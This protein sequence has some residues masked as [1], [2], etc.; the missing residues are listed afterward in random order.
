MMAFEKNQSRGPAIK[1][2]VSQVSELPVLPQVVYKIV[3]LTSSSRTTPADIE[4]IV[5]TDP[6]LVAKLLVLANSSHFG[7]DIPTN[8]IVEAA[9]RLGVN[10]IRQL[11]MT[12]TMFDMFVGKAD[13]SSRR[14]REWWRHSVDAAVCAQTL[15]EHLGTEPG[16]AYTCGLLHDMGKPLLERHGIGDYSEVEAKVASGDTLLKAEYEVYGCDHTEIGANVAELL[17]LP[18]AIVQAVRFHHDPPSE[19]GIPE[20][21]AITAIAN[22]F[23]HLLVTGRMADEETVFTNWAAEKLKLDGVQLNEIFGACRVAV[24][25]G[26]HQ[27]T[28]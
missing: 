4:H 14:R 26:M 17:R 1:A 12:V 7:G 28:A 18:Q 24:S 21:V 16:E 2:V 22:D 3:E 23:A 11:A 10:T 19:D 5:A 6:G 20:Y 27:K 13:V 15:A 9:Q 8:S 25:H